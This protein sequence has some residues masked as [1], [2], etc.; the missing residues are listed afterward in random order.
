MASL[1]QYPL[2]SRNEDISQIIELY[3]L[4]IDIDKFL[5]ALRNNFATNLSI[6]IV[7]EYLFLG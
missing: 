3:K 2:V 4:G 6:S 5:A 7:T 1:I